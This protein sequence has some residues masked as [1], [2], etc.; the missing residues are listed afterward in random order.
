MGGS[1]CAITLSMQFDSGP[2]TAPGSARA[3]GPGSS[4]RVF[5]IAL[6]RILTGRFDMYGFVEVMHH[7]VR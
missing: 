1:V 2:G 3:S 6:D 4:Q 7:T 5:D